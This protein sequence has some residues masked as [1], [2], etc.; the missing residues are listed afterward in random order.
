M[1]GRPCGNKRIVG[2][3]RFVVVDV[4]GLVLALSITEANLGERAGALLVLAKLKNRFSRLATIL[5]D[6]GFDGIEFITQVKTKF[7]LTLEVVYQVLGIKGFQVLPKRW[8]V[9]R[10]FGWFSFH[11]RL[12]KD[13]EVKVA[14]AESFIYWTMIRIMSRR[15]RGTQS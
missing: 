9:E 11:R 4:L 5:A 12:S 1:R 13:Y 3:K 7:A 15:V 14:H 2:R 6:Q 8:I 10:T